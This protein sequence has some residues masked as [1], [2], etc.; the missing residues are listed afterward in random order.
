MYNLAASFRVPQQ[1]HILQLFVFHLTGVHTQHACRIQTLKKG[2]GGGG[3]NQKFLFSPLS[4]SLFL[5]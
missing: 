3:G 1:I 5:K 4:L 2:G